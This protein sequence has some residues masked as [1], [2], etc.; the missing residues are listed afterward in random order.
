MLYTL[1]IRLSDKTLKQ[2]T[3]D[4]IISPLCGNLKVVKNGFS[5]II[6]SGGNDIDLPSG[7]IEKRLANRVPYASENPCFIIIVLSFV[8][9]M[10]SSLFETIKDIFYFY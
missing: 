6:A 2:P 9:N 8:I 7:D 10:I 3:V 4:L 1:V 5:A